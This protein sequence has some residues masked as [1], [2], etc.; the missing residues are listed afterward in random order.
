MCYK[1]KY[2]VRYYWNYNKW[3]C[4]HLINSV[5]KT[6]EIQLANRLMILNILEK[7][8]IFNNIN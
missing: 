7:N 4:V 8:K 2:E 6:L 5:N 1:Y 3:Y